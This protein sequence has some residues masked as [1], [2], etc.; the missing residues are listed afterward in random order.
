ME[1]TFKE[2]LEAKWATSRFVCLSLDPVLDQEKMPT[3]LWGHPK[4]EMAWRFL[5]E[6]IESTAN[7]VAAFKLNTSFFKDLGY[8]CEDIYRD[9]CG[10]IH[11]EYSHVVLI[12]DFDAGSAGFFFDMRRFDAVMV[13]NDGGQEAVQ[14][15]LDRAD[16]GVFVLC[17]T[18]DT[19]S[20]GIQN[21]MVLVSEEEAEMF[22]LPSM[23]PPLEMTAEEA[24]MMKRSRRQPQ[25]HLMPHYQLVAANVNRFW[26]KQG[27]CGLLVSATDPQAI[28]NVRRVAPKLPLF[29][30]GVGNPDGDLKKSVLSAHRQFLVS[31][32]SDFLYQSQGENFP[33]VVRDNVLELDKQ[34]HAALIAER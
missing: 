7:L 28:A 26:N 4:E 21:R 34:I 29:I 12:S 20:G 33:K 30:E 15:F 8:R 17:R 31:T 6:I 27:N 3:H 22:R 18:S 16:K 13:H 2:K 25:P 32:S 5:K 14:P 23:L 19:G 9:V 10:Y 1:K 11:D 24:R